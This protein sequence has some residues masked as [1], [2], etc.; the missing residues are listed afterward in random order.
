MAKFTNP[1]AVIGL[2]RFG[3]ALALE[4][5]STGTEVLG[6]DAQEDIVQSLNGQLTHVVQGDATREET[7]RQLA[8]PEFDRAVVAIGSDI[9]ASLLTTSLLL[10]FEI[11]EVW[12]KAVTDAHGAILERLGTHHVVYP[13][14]E[15]GRRV[16][17]LVRG[18]MQ[19]YVEIGEGFAMVKTAPPPDMVGT[20]LGATGARKRYGVT[21]TGFR[22][23]DQE[24]TY[25]TAETVL[26]PTDTIVVTGPVRQVE[27]FSQRAFSD[28]GRR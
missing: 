28:G 27:A 8:L 1:V 3:Q 20:A 10:Q 6:I 17:H 5:M 15:M 22:R 18:K 12:A 13:E 23:Q 14:Q 26:R 9:E 24:W 4:L 19:D 16:A 25:A 11:P 7:L 21:V 2:G